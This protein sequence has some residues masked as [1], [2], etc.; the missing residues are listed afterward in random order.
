MS[1]V[2]ADEGS[3]MG[4]VAHS[5]PNFAATRASFGDAFGP[6]PIRTFAGTPPDGFASGGTGFSASLN[7][8]NQAVYS[9]GGCLIFAA[10]MSEMRHPMDFWKALLC[11]E[12]FIYS[13][14]LMF[15]LY[16]YSYQ[17]QYSFNPVIQGLS[18]WGWQTVT[19]ILSLVSG[20]IV[21]ALYGNIGMK[22][23]YVEFL[24][25]LFG[26]PALTEPMGKMLWAVAIPVY[27]SLAFL[28][29]AAV[30][31]FSLVSGFIGA[32]FIL[33][34]TYTLP[35]LLGLGYYIR[36]D[37]MLPEEERFDPLSGTY[38]YVDGG[39]WRYW[40][41][42]KRRPVFNAWNIF[43]MLGGLV[44]TALGMYSSIVGLVDAFN[45]KS[46]ATSFGCSSPV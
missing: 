40:R 32:L 1:E 13:I 38:S 39:F 5:P 10:F 26:L 21:A 43:Y 18:P 37:A 6:G 20:L 2:M 8:L 45:G 25:S 17:G 15:G 35:A 16:V 36:M 14:Y 41:G 27:W 33:S 11:G 46:Q 4:V 44:T 34:F 22:V 30:P 29:G 42:F 31:Q 24:Q 7:G 28:V 3:S 19:N 12:L 23:F 9:Y